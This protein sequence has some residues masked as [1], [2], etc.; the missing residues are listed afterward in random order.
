MTDRPV[1]PTEGDKAAFL[2]MIEDRRAYHAKSI[3]EF[4]AEDA[5]IQAIYNASVAVLAAMQEMV[6]GGIHPYFI[7]ARMNADAAFVA[8]RWALLSDDRV[9]AVMLM[10]TA[11][12]ELNAG[13]EKQ[14]DIEAASGRAN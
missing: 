11:A 7:L 9:M 6:E 14:L 1:T 4:S 5:T 8:G 13:I 2:A 10:T 12:G 3:K